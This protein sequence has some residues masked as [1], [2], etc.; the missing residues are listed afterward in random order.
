MF[1]KMRNTFRLIL[2]VGLT[3]APLSYSI[4]YKFNNPKTL[5]ILFNARNLVNEKLWA[6]AIEQYAKL[7]KIG[8]SELLEDNRLSQTSVHWFRTV[9]E[10]V[11]HDL[12]SL[13]AE[14][15]KVYD[16][17][18]GEIAQGEFSTSEREQ[19]S[20]QLSILNDFY[21]STRGAAAL[22][23]L[24][25][26][27]FQK[28]DIGA[29]LHAYQQLLPENSFRALPYHHPNAEK[30]APE[31]Y[32]YEI[33][34]LYAL[35]E[36]R[37]VAEALKEFAEKYSRVEGRLFG[38]EGPLLA[39]LISALR[40]DQFAP[41]NS[42]KESIASPTASWQLAGSV[43]IPLAPTKAIADGKVLA[44]YHASFERDYFWFNGAK[45][46]FKLSLNLREEL[47][48]LS[49]ADP[50]FRRSNINL[51]FD[52]QPT[53]FGLRTE[54]KSLVLTT[55]S[56]EDQ[57]SLLCV[58]TTTSN[59]K[60]NWKIYPQILKLPK[61]PTGTD[62]S[63][64]TVFEDEEVF[65]GVPAVT[66]DAV[67][68]TVSQKQNSTYTRFP[69]KFFQD[70]FTYV[71]KIDLTTGHPRWV[72]LVNHTGL[73]ELPLPLLRS[74]R[75]ATSL[76]LKD[77]Q[78]FFSDH[79]GTIGAL[80]AE[81]GSLRWLLKYPIEKPL[82]EKFPREASPPLVKPT[83]LIAAPVDYNRVLAIEPW[84]G[85]IDWV[86][87]P[88]GDGDIIYL[89]GVLADGRVAIAGNRVTLLDK[90]KG[91]IAAQ[92]SS[93]DASTVTSGKG[94]VVG[95]QVLWPTTE[96]IYRLHW[97]GASLLS[98]D[99]IAKERGGNLI[100]SKNWLASLRDDAFLLYVELPPPGS[101][102]GKSLND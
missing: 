23:S 7:L 53:F 84:S 85:K 37:I 70:T 86:S 33:L 29:A 76:S 35:G 32:A 52:P 100:A 69:D 92:W 61:P 88:W 64:T 83:R 39:S 48:M 54:R 12:C 16:K 74:K 10:V 71:A 101:N 30:T 79:R 59:P 36:N 1:S 45:T 94:L 5:K 99:R 55:G 102:R 27:Y 51:M 60:L 49:T 34:C 56:S 95:N 63:F 73:T 98:A 47:A 77:E 40:F 17:F 87:A 3:L 6:E 82:Y 31:I 57:N 65:E 66:S 13:P 2:C 19:L 24:G 67:F 43:A 38:R 8:S 25:G 11:T 75:G 80:A 81:N 14:G 58:D 91:Q 15:L 18:A 93:R 96:G 78:V 50:N 68:V 97:N 4:D 62:E 72:Q 20:T 90:A 28:G 89:L 41:K 46:L 21:C 26:L 44:P 9:R 22:E 42:G